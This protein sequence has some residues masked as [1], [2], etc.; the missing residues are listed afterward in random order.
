M[1]PY[2]FP[3]IGYFQLMHLSDEFIIFDTV[4]YRKKGWINRNRVLHPKGG[5]AYINVPI[6]KFHSNTLI[7]DILIDNQE[8]WK[9]SIINRLKHYYKEAPYKE[10]VLSFLKECFKEDFESISE[11]NEHLLRRICNYL[12]IQCSITT[13]SKSNFTD[14]RATAADEW[15]LN[16]CKTVHA[17]TYLNAPGGITF[18]DRNKYK[19]EDIEIQFINPIFNQYKQSFEQFEPGLSIIDVMMFN[20]IEKIYEMLGNYEVIH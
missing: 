1:Q 4:Q 9:T 8:D 2:F 13:L 15:G 14:E 7:K 5:S 3:Y 20:S 16:I 17:D 6:K 12:N 10:E 19:K 18:F 11:L